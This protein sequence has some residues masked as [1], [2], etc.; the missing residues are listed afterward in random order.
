MFDLHT[1]NG[2]SSSSLDMILAP[3]IH[4]DKW[5]LIWQ[6]LFSTQIITRES[7]SK[8]LMLLST[9]LLKN[10]GNARHILTSSRVIC[11]ITEKHVRSSHPLILFFQPHSHHISLGHHLLPLYLTSLPLSQPE[12]NLFIPFHLNPAL[13]M[14]SQEV[15]FR[16]L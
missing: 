5:H 10:D 16:P 7:N 14:S 15:K 6:S 11:W 4:W 2:S 1:E 8:Q 12:L 13:S 3:L 9:S